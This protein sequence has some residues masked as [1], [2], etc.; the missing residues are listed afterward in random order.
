V[1]GRGVG[2]GGGGAGDVRGRGGEALM[3]GGCVR[4]WCM[5]VTI[6]TEI[7]SSM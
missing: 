4:G 6:Q 7:V 1:G 3:S 5:F 2:G